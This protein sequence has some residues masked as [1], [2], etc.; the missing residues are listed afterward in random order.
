MK[1]IQSRFRIPTSACLSESLMR[2]R[3]HSLWC[4]AVSWGKNPSPGGVM[5]VCL[6]LDKTAVDV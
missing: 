1:H 5:Y 4:L 2:E 6:A 3:V